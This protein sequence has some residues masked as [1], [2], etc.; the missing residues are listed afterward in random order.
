MSYCDFNHKLF[1]PYISNKTKIEP[2]LSDDWELINKAYN[3]KDGVALKSG[4]LNQIIY[5]I[6]MRRFITFCQ[7]FNI[8]LTGNM[9]SG[10]FSVGQ[11]RSVYVKEDYYKWD[12]KYS[13][14]T[15]N[16]ISIKDAK[17]GHIYRTVCGLSVIYLGAKYTARIKINDWKDLSQFTKIT[18][19]HYIHTKI[20]FDD[21]NPRYGI[22]PLRTYKFTQ[23]MGYALDADEIDNIFDHYY[24]SNS[25]LV[26]L[27]DKRPKGD[28]TY[29]IIPTIRKS[30]SYPYKNEP[31]INYYTPLFAKYENKYW[32][33]ANSQSLSS[34][35]AY[36]GNTLKY[37]GDHKSNACMY[38][39]G[40]E[41]SVKVN[42]EFYRIGI[43]SENK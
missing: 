28:P 40:R 10:E 5:D 26:Y 23:D 29:G 42:D 27:N 15:E 8:T 31:T 30:Y 12:E 25:D 2:K 43:I 32:K 21:N 38:I 6:P 24:H 19:I 37:T 1:Q 39:G 3:T 22:Q 36:D 41:S 17:V 33:M 16:I 11:D 13:K 34:A 14:R 9:L 4:K 20:D 7:K 18:K 35:H